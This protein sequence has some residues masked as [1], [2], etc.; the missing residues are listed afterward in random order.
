M[1]YLKRLTVFALLVSAVLWLMN[2]SRFTPA[3]DADPLLLSHRGVHQTHSTAPRD[4]SACT[5]KHIDP[6]S[7]SF[8]ENTIPSMQAAILAGANVIELDVH[9]T[10]E[11]VLAVFHDWTLDCRT[12]GTGVTEKASFDVLQTLDVGYGYSADGVTYPLR[13]QGVGLMPS[14]TQ[15]LDAN[16]GARYL[17]NFKSR[18]ADEG[19]ALAELLTNPDFRAQIWGV[20]GGSEPT[21]AAIRA[22]P[23]LAGF[24]KGDIKRCLGHYMALGWAGYV[25]D[26]CRNTIVGVPQNVAPY[27]WGWPHRFTQRMANV[28][29]QVILWGP[30]DG[31]GFSSGVDTAA[32]ADKIPQGFDGYVWTNKIETIGPYL[33][34]TN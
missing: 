21:H 4:G 18:N 22:V 6:P 13:G 27:V 16:L 23:G 34:G 7:H 5:A 25:P 29:T 24:D 2:T 10:P 14:L 12:D 28:G 3:T 30:Y 33:R 31:T 26:A 19:T 8:I 9:M 11:G 1:T 17:V 20:Y 15:V 32:A